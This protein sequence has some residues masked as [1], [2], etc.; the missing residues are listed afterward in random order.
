ML[1]TKGGRTRGARE[2]QNDAGD[3]PAKAL[4]GNKRF[5]I[6]RSCKTARRGFD[7]DKVKTKDL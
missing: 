4:S 1:A 6:W 3:D 5:G 2:K 7:G